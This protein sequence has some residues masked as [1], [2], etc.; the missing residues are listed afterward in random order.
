MDPQRGV[1]HG[2][3]VCSD[4][5]VIR[6]VEAGEGPVLVLLPGWSQTADIFGWQLASLSTSYR[7]ISIDHRGHGNSSNP[8]F[9]YHIHRLAA[10]VREVLRSRD[11]DQV[12]LL[13]HSMGC[14]VIWSYLELFGRDRLASVVLVDQM[15]CAL[16]NPAWSDAEALRAGA[17]M[18]ADSLFSFTDRLRGDGPDPRPG[19]IEDMVSQGI[20]PQSLDWLKKQAQTLDRS[21]AADLIYDVVTHDWRGFVRHIAL[22]TLVVAG[23]PASAPIAS[24][25]WLAE[26]IPGARFA[27]VPGVGGGTHFPFVESPEGFDAVL[28]QFLSE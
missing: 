15:P 11:L 18:D 19:F 28:C 12:H 13:G 22:P 26:Q 2:E 17:T 14:A 24:R 21:H 5:A 23:D 10:D 8:G 25:R 9:G 16:R 27:C 1:T 3:T 6:H 20:S 4:G 7:V